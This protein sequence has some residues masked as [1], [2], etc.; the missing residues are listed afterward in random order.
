M[1]SQ[2]TPPP[3][4]IRWERITDI[5][6][7]VIALLSVPLL[8]MEYS[9]SQYG[10]WAAPFDWI[11]S[12]LYGIDLAGRVAIHGPD[13]I[14]FLR[15]RWADSVIVVLSLV[16]FL[17]PLRILRST[18][19]LLLLRLLRF[20]MFV[21]LF[22]Y[23]VVRIWQ[24]SQGKSVVWGALVAIIGSGTAVWLFER[25]HSNGIDSLGKLLW[26]MSVTSSTVGYGDL[27]PVTTGGKIAA[28]LLIVG[29]ITLFGM[30]TA[31]LA[32][33]FAAS[34][35]DDDESEMAR[36]LERMA[37]QMELL[38]EDLARERSDGLRKSG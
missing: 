9:G 15:N 34:M 36:Q 13:R 22:W 37:Q 12:I 23:P 18:R 35:D 4:I 29:G 26:W 16:P 28:V 8:V 10:Q 31:N 21:Q 1:S 5:P 33:V 2:Y 25:G 11:I 3:V 27:A 14:Q 17:T 20:A 30:I 24:R 7:L 6:L 19:I 38:R 32:A